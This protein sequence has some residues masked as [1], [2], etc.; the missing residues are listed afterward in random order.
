[1]TTSYKLEAVK[2]LKA[3]KKE[4]RAQEELE[5]KASKRGGRKKRSS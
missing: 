2:A 3:Q 4:A 1:M 5:L